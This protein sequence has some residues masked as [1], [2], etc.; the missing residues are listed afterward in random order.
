M[1]AKSG[2]VDHTAMPSAIGF[3]HRIEL[4]GGKRQV[5]PYAD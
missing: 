2:E 4:M 3:V 5:R 1:G